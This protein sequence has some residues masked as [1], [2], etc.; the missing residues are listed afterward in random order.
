[1]ALAKAYRASHALHT[2]PFRLR[3]PTITILHAYLAWLGRSHRQLAM[4]VCVTRTTTTQRASL[5]AVMKKDSKSL[6]HRLKLLQDVRD[7][8]AASTAKAR[9]KCGQAMYA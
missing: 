1:M 3:Y 8:E 4:F 2:E 9:R 6:H 7:V 5:S